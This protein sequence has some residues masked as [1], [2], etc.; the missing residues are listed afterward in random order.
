MVIELK[1]GE[2][3]ILE[4]WARRPFTAQGLA[5]RCRIVLGAAEGRT[6]M[7]IATQSGC[8]TNTVSK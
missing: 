6:N 2:R 5:M 8:S 4:R 7:D 3:E 1:D